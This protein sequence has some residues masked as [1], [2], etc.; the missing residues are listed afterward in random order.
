MRFPHA[1]WTEK[2]YYTGFMKESQRTQF[3]DLPLIDG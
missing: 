3:T 1:R 2:N